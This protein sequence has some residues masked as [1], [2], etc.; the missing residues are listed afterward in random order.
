MASASLPSRRDTRSTT[1]PG[2]ETE[3][4]RA[5]AAPLSRRDAPPSRADVSCSAS[6]AESCSP[7]RRDLLCRR[8]SLEPSA[9]ASPQSRQRAAV[10]G[11]L[12]RPA[13]R[14]VVRV[15]EVSTDREVRAGKLVRRGVGESQVWVR[16]V[17][18]PLCGG[19]AASSQSAALRIR[20]PPRGEGACFRD[21][22]RAV[23]GHGSACSP[24]GAPGPGASSISPRAA[25]L[26]HRS[27]RRSGPMLPPQPAWRVSR[28]GPP[29]VG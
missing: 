10:R 5:S 15:G 7:G 23:D 6:K 29:G 25:G 12:D 22:V 26:P 28:G 13:R 4:S 8:S 11:R 17:H 19:R 16:A 14:L 18:G 2:T 27:Q 3:A 9:P 24:C 21:R 1:L 20:S